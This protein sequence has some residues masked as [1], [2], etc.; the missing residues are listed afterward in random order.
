VF[1]EEH[2]Y[3]Y[4]FN[5]QEVVVKWY[6]EE[7]YYGYILDGQQYNFGFINSFKKL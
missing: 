3:N 2:A 6:Q 1:I 4:L 5:Q 7:G